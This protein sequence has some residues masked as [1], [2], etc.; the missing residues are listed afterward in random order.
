MKYSFLLLVSILLILSSCD[1]N[2]DEIDLEPE[3]FRLQGEWELLATGGAIHGGGYD[4]DFSKL[5]L[6][7]GTDTTYQLYENNDLIIHGILN[8]EFQYGIK[9]FV[10]HPDQSYPQDS[11]RIFDFAGKQFQWL[12]GDSLLMNDFCADCYTHL[13]L[14]T[15]N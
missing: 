12:S 2:T 13:F 9:L 11:F 3:P 1:K 6:E 10:F 7:E 15:G 4:A 8:Y 14:K 5:I